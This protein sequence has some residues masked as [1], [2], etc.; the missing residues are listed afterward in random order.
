[1]KKTQIYAKTAPWA[2]A[3]LVLALILP[4]FLGLTSFLSPA[5]IIPV[6]GSNQTHTLFQRVQ[7]ILSSFFGAS[8]KAPQTALETAERSV[9]ITGWYRAA[10]GE[11]LV[12]EAS[13]ISNPDHSLSAF[14]AHWIETAPYQYRRVGEETTLTFHAGPDGEITTAVLS[15]GQVY[16]RLNWTE[17]PSLKSTLL[18]A[19]L[20]A[21]ATAAIY[22]VR[23]RPPVPV[24]CAEQNTSAD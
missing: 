18:A 1:M 15:E 14:Q 20:L 17:S 3:L 6:T 13:I 5:P 10:D 9:R 16:R 11:T 19:A 4:L 22:R 23:Q 24:R 7:G 21:A 2:A 12:P 8:S